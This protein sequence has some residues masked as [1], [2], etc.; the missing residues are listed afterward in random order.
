MS[1][2]AFIV[3]NLARQ[4]MRTLLTVV[5]IG[6][7]IT[8][9]VALGAVTAG[10]RNAAT[11]LTH[12][13]GADFMVAQKGAADLTFSTLAARDLD[14][15]RAQEGVAG[16]TG[17]LLHVSRVGS[18]PFFFAIGVELERVRAFAPRLAAGRYPRDGTEIAVGVRAAADLSVAPGSTVTIER[19]PFTVVGVFDAGGLFENGGGYLALS[20][21]QEITRKRDVLTAIYVELEEGADLDAVAARLEAESDALAVVSTADEYG[22]V[23]QGL[24]ILD[25][26]N[27]AIS[28]LAVVIGAIGVL[29]TMIMSVF[30]RTREIGIL[31]AVGWRGGRIVRMIIG[32]SIVVCAVATGVGIGL[33]IAAT[34]ALVTIPA[35]GSFISPSYGPAIFVRAVVIALGV[36]LVGA[37]YPALRAVR[38]SPME[39]LR[40]E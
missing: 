26:A 1:F 16:A 19:R 39:A 2:A 24:E 11:D 20:A 7:G 40:H 33:G 31:R 4:R 29:N 18:N 8:T 34:R 30:E 6:I 22:E 21:V 35:I 28:L 3:R 32:E 27:L 37:L 12:L 14:L 5:G 10:F 36:A 38:L 15:V 23:D 25:A 13:G 17:V 9:V